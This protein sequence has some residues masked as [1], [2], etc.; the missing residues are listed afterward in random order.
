MLMFFLYK[1]GTFIPFDET[2]ILKGSQF[3]LGVNGVTVADKSLRCL[4]YAHRNMGTW[5][6]GSRV[7]LQSLILCEIFHSVAVGSH[8]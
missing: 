6:C 2:R 7:E 5:V 8:I 3:S 1:V 4:G